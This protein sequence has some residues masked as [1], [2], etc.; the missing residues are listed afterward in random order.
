MDVVEPFVALVVY[1]TTPGAPG[2]SALLRAPQGQP[3]G[4]SMHVFVL[5]ENS[6]IQL[7]A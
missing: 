3:R 6:G 5:K 4:L 1:P 2:R 7:I